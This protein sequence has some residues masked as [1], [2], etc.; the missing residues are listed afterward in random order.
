VTYEKPISG[1][2]LA[3]GKKAGNYFSVQPANSKTE[4]VDHVTFPG[5]YSYEV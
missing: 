3:D 2:Q 4:V 5:E 1:N